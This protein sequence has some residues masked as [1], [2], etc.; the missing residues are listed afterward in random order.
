MQRHTRFILSLLALGLAASAQTLAAESPPVVAHVD[1]QRYL[2]DW[3]EIKK[4]PNR[5]Q[6]QCTGNTTATYSA[7]DDGRLNVTNRCLT[8][9][10]DWA[11]AEGI[12]RSVDP[13]SNA[14]LEVS[15]VRLFGWNL[16]WG[17]YWVVDL[18][19]DYSYV[20]V[21]HPQRRYGWI[22]SRTPTLAI[23]LAPRLRE[24]GYD[25]ADFVVTRQGLP[26]AQ[27]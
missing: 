26:S 10:G 25:P 15:F 21:G 2:G 14:K 23:D 9:D 1:L 12:A 20:I 16:F 18:A 11:L 8:Y 19:A 5:F 17:D 22:L 27:P 24:L 6:R 4:I 13:V 3:Y 7:R